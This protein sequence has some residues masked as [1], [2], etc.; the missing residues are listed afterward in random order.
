MEF[1]RIPNFTF[2]LQSVNLPGISMNEIYRHTPFADIMI[3]GDKA[4][5]DTLNTAFLIDEDTRSWFEIYNWLHSLAKVENF[6]E[7]KDLIDKNGGKQNYSL[8]TTSDAT[9][10]ILNNNNQPA[11]R[12]SLVGVFPTMLSSLNFDSAQDASVTMVGDATFRFSYYT[13]TRLL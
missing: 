11:I 2:F 1:K 3:P 4:Q 6:N 5:Y 7:Y 8:A 13:I 10:T 9:L 12:A